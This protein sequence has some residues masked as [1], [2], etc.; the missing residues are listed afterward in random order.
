MRLFILVLS[1]ACV[2]LY[3]YALAG[4]VGYS[5]GKG[6]PDY[7]AWGLSVG[8]L[9]GAAAIGLWRKWMKE[10]APDML[11]FDVD[12]VLIDTCE[13]FRLATAETVR[14]C[15]EHL[16]GGSADCEGYTPE[17]FHLCKS[18]PAFNDDAVVAWALL[19]CM[20]RSRAR[21]GST[22]M[23]E[24]F[25]SLEAWRSELDTYGQDE[26]VEETSRRETNRLSLSVVRSVMEEIYY[27]EDT[28]VQCKGKPVHNIGGD[29]FWKLEKPTLSQH[30]KDLGLPVGI[31]TG[32]SRIEMSLAQRQLGW[33]DFPQDMAVTSDEGVLKP[34]PLG[35]AMLCERSG[36]RSPFFFGDTASDK[37][38]WLAFRKGTFVAIGPILKTKADGFLYFDTLEDALSALL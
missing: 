38:A 13:S 12:G 6:R 10:T 21:T 28:Y 3:G 2:V 8:T 32:R 16:L 35:L 24:T 26:T 17:Y 23:K 25:P 27:G 19:R 37:E 18:H 7:I 9:C 31:Y 22:S 29:G 30:W 15:W 36:A 11:I 14:W 34:S 33:L 20:E 4:Y 1:V 5:F